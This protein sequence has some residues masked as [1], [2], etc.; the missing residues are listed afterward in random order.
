MFSLDRRVQGDD[1]HP[2][3]PAVVPGLAPGEPVVPL[4]PGEE[5]SPPVVIVIPPPGSGDG[6]YPQR[7]R[8]G[9]GVP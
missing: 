8:E 5:V 7:G 9:Q 6:F 4:S 2:V 3:V 1:P